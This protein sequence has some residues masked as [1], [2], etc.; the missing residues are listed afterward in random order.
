M[1]NL[2]IRWSKVQKINEYSSKEEK[3]KEKINQTLKYHNFVCHSCVC[4][5]I[6]VFV[7]FCQGENLT[8]IE[9]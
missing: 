3:V 7:F 8:K 2:W 4:R 1:S 5:K 9:K 6:F